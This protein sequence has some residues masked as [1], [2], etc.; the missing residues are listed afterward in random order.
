MILVTLG[1]CA[2]LSFVC[3]VYIQNKPLSWILTILSVIGMVIS[4]VFI[5]KNDTDHYGMKQETKTTYQPLYSVSPSKQMKMLLYQPIGTANKHQVYI[6]QKSENAKKK[7]HTTVNDT[8]N[9]VIKGN[10][11]PRIETQTTRWQYQNGA[12]K[13][14][15]GIAGESGKLVKR[16]N[17]LYV[18]KD[19]LVLSTDQAKAL[20]KK[21]KDK[22]YQAQLKAQGKAFVTKQ[23]MAAMKQNP[24]MSKAQQAQLQKKA[25][26]EFQAQAMQKL[27]RSITK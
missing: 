21:L 9:H 4:T 10:G 25:T 26:A 12:A 17:K 27:V 16:V 18:N 19:W 1:I 20:Q 15:F 14:W 13:F 11:V 22:T 5:V 8:T 23:M 24:K 6:Y 7:S 3:F 2:I